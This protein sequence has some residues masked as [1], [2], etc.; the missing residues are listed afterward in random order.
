MQCQQCRD[1]AIYSISPHAV[2]WFANRNCH[3]Y[4]IMQ[5]YHI[6]QH[7]P[8]TLKVFMVSC[9]NNLS[10]FLTCSHCPSTTLSSEASTKLSMACITI[11]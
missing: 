1:I 2:M 3:E 10:T 11:L 8:I 9:D 5:C 6:V 7:T 4:T